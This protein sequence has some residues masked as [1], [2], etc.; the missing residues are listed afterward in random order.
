MIDLIVLVPNVTV[1]GQEWKSE[2]HYLMNP[3]PS[4]KKASYDETPCN[5]PQFKVYLHAHF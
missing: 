5:I 4:S 2:G 3:R 1:T